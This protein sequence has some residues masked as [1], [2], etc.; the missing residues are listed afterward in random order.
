M[1]RISVWRGAM[2]NLAAAELL[3]AVV[4]AVLMI[5]GS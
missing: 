3:F 1:L 4:L 5:V 2:S